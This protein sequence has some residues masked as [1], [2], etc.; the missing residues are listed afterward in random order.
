[1]YVFYIIY[2][3]LISGFQVTSSKPTFIYSKT[4]VHSGAHHFLLFAVTINI[5][6]VY[7][8]ETPQ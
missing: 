2:A 5:N 6:C 8:R 3:F 4:G 1:M 7:S